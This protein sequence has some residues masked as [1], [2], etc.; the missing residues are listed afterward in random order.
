MAK[1]SSDISEARA[2]SQARIAARKEAEAQQTA[3]KGNSRTQQSTTNKEKKT[4]K[5]PKR[6]NTSGASVASSAMPRQYFGFII[7]GV[8]VAFLLLCRLFYLQVINYGEYSDEVQATYTETVTVS[9]ARGTI[10]DRNG[11]VLAI[12]VAAYT[13]YANPQEI[14]GDVEE[15]A[16]T[17]A[18][19]LDADAET[20]QENIEW[21]QE[22]DK[23]FVY[24][25]R[26]ATLEEG[27]AV[28][29]LDIDGIYLL[30]D[31][32]REYPYGEIAGQ[33][34]G[35]VDADGNAICGLEL[36]YDDILSG[37]AGVYVA[38]TGESGLPI[39]GGLV[40]SVAAVAGEDIMITIDVELQQEVEKSLTD[41][42]DD[43]V[44][45]GASAIV[46]DAETGE[47][48]AMASLPLFDPS[49]TSN[50]EEGATTLWPIS[51]NYE[52]GSVF[53]TVSATALLEHE[54]VEA[55]T[56]IYVP[57]TLEANGQTVSDSD[58]SRGAQIMDL[59]NIIAVSSNVGI[60]SMVEEYL[61][62]DT[63]YKD[64]LRYGLTEATGVDFPGEASG[65]L[66]DYSD[67]TDIQAYNITFGQGV[68][69][70]GLQLTRFY[71]ALANGGV[72]NTPHFLMSNLTTGEDATFD[73]KTIINNA[74]AVDEVTDVLRHVVTEG[75]SWRAS[76]SDYYVVG[77]S[78]TAEIY[79]DGAY[80]V[81]EYNR[82][83]VGYLD[84]A[85]MSL[86]VYCCF[87]DVAFE[88]S[89]A[90]VTFREIM[91]A[92]IERF[93]VVSFWDGEETISPGVAIDVE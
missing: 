88:G 60:A 29:A 43:E 68:S 11:N 70:T 16:A 9:A 54:L 17:L 82:S 93:N 38:E 27:E 14:T 64:I 22:N 8:V 37:T 74:E 81:D 89:V 56:Q 18:E 67:W 44:A 42:S 15:I 25:K 7:A 36:Y 63:L 46:Y 65:Y 77:K 12:S 3:Q 87:N 5:A 79:E 71:G 35:Y 85:S 49:D 78:G 30:D 90:P 1:K 57:V 10:Y 41:A 51:I 69:V 31:T 66:A 59:N 32:R 80:K 50:T 39:P 19:I 76:I 52:P 34:V 28:S 2:A 24:V 40:E 61:G 47:I 33:I 83:F 84:D 21:G 55:D 26:Q 13:I 86:V 48:L 6:S 91:E 20:I 92:A 58:S 75:T 73:T 72:A 45:S 53:K 23:L 4:K 62:F